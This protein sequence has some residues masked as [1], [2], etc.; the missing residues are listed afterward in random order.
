MSELGS[1]MLEVKD[2]FKLAVKEELCTGCCNCMITCP[3][4]ALMVIENSGGKGGDGFEFKV[5]GGSAI[6]LSKECNGCGRCVE[7]CPTGALG[8]DAKKPSQAEREI[9]V[10]ELSN[11]RGGGAVVEKLEAVETRKIVYKIDEK[12]RTMLE[13]LAGSFENAKVK[14]MLE[15]GKAKEAKEEVL[16]KLKQE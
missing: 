10:S 1:L 12:R 5:E 2:I 16:K 6:V 11:A 3:I 14:V 8:I 15:T 4:N 7:A 9:K 13:A